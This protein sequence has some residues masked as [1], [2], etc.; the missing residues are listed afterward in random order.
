MDEN[1]R[2][3]R[4]KRKTKD[5]RS[6]RKDLGLENRKRVLD[7]RSAMDNIKKERKGRK[8][9]IKN[10]KYLGK[11]NMVLRGAFCKEK[12]KEKCPLSSGLDLTNIEKKETEGCVR[13]RS[14][15][16]GDKRLGK[17]LRFRG[18]KIIVRESEDIKKAVSKKGS[19][20]ENVVSIKEEAEYLLETQDIGSELSEDD[21]VIFVEEVVNNPKSKCPVIVKQEQNI[22]VEEGINEFEDDLLLQV[23]NETGGI[24]SGD[25]DSSLDRMAVLKFER[26]SRKFRST[27]VK[28]KSRI[29]VGKNVKIN[30]LFFE[31]HPYFDDSALMCSAH[32]IEKFV[33]I[34]GLQYMR[35]KVAP[36]FTTA[37]PICKV[38]R[39]YWTYE[40]GDGVE[41]VSRSRV[42]HKFFF[43]KGAPIDENDRCV[44]CC[45]YLLSEYHQYM[46]VFKFSPD[47]DVNQL[48]DWKESEH[49]ACAMHFYSSKSKFIPGRSPYNWGDD[50]VKFSRVD[51]IPEL[52]DLSF[53]VD[54]SIPEEY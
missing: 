4:L 54:E 34:N 52:Q 13:E 27:G 42:Q 11:S 29:G 22:E 21:D 51:E 16:L 36:W 43:R 38:E 31:K 26:N 1:N 45:K 41:W 33:T 23:A 44:I 53:D 40:A 50:S 5:R 47:P 14:E 3:N 25:K 10:K 30:S 32:D 6:K 39:R 35:D 12:K 7:K 18:N 24:E 20:C 8:K 49:K 37:Q 2:L 46:P 15:K 28:S 48:M 17:K 9:K 19:K